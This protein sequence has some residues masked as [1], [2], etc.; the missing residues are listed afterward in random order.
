MSVVPSRSKALAKALPPLVLSGC[1]V[2]PVSLEILPDMKDDR[3][4]EIAAQVFALHRAS[5][6]W[7]GDLLNYLGRSD[8]ERRESEAYQLAERL[9]GY[10]RSWL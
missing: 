8:G 3:L 1:R 9:T 4:A 2:T 6:W 7:I 5:G 10:S